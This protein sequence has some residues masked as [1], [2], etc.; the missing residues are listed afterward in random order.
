MRRRDAAGHKRRSG[1]IETAVPARAF[2]VHADLR[3]FVVFGVGKR[4]VLAFIPSPASESLNVI[5]NFLL[6]VDAEAV[7]D[8]PCLRVAVTSGVG[9][10]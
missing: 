10:T 9:V 7:L 5:G 1:A 8:G 3:P 6:E 4:F 2:H